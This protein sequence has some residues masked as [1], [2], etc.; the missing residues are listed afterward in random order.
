VG[1][2]ARVSIF[3]VV[4]LALVAAGCG[5]HAAEATPP[6]T[7]K[8]WRAVIT[9]WSMYGR[10]THQHPCAAVVV[11]RSRIV[12]ALHEGMPLIHAL[13]VFERKVCPAGDVWAVQTGMSDREV[14]ALAGPP[15]P[16]R[17]GP[18]CWNYHASKSGTSIDALAFCFDR[19]GHVAAIKTGVHG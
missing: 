11:A 1:S 15:I 4:A 2:S 8:E 12:P 10:F 16:W 14:A 19:T 9:D 6:V 13:D 5:H 3:S 18:H 17:S 7:G